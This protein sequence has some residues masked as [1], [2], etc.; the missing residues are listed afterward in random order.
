MKEPVNYSELYNDELF[1]P[2]TVKKMLYKFTELFYID[3]E[4]N[5][6]CS[7]PN[8]DDTPL[9]E[10]DLALSNYVKKFIK[11]FKDQ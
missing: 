10:F 2:T 5:V 4:G 7:T 3:S 1:E 6:L 9:D 8:L 11:T